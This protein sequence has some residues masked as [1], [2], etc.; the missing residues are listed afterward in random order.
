MTT[1]FFQFNNKYYKQIY[2]TLIGSSLS[3]LFAD[4]VMDDLET[5]YF[6]IL[7]NK[8]NNNISV[9]LYNNGYI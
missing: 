7:K 6:Q 8:F 4:I 9:V 1:H 5:E 2:D 3:L